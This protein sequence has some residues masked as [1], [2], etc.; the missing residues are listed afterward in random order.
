MQKILNNLL[1]VKGKIVKSNFWVEDRHF[2]VFIPD[3]QYWISI[4]D[5]LINREYEFFSEFGLNNFTGLVIDAGAHVG[6]FSLI[7]ANFANTVIA[8]EPNKKNYNLLRRNVQHN[9]ADNIKL[10]AK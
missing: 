5:I 3:D 8:I 4:K 2:E 7:A 9:K 1:S 6:L 10:I